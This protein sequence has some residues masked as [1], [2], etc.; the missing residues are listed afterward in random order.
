M[1]ESIDLI[2]KKKTTKLR[3]YFEFQNQKCYDDVINYLWNYI[4]II[5]R[6]KCRN[7][8]YE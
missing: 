8:K 2:K 7:K 5:L 1:H 4:Q 6:K 3:K